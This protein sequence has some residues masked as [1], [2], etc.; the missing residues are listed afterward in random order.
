MR[1]NK[2]QTTNNELLKEKLREADRQK[3]ELQREIEALRAEVMDI[4]ASMS[5][6]SAH[7]VLLR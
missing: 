7:Q 5:N 3:G 2:E 6:I 4:N 1:K